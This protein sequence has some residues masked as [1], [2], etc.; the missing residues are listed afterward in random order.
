MA[1]EKSYTLEEINAA[2]R[3]IDLIYTDLKAKGIYL[4]ADIKKVFHD[5]NN[6]YTNIKKK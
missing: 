3:A 4:S 6:F 5:H 1:F 2:H